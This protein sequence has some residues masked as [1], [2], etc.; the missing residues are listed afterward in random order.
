M[1]QSER[2][3]LKAILKRPRLTLRET[4]LLAALYAAQAVVCV[5]LLKLLFGRFGQ[6]GVLWANISAVLALQPGF[7]QS[8][9]TSVIRILA[10]VV[11]AGVALLVHRIPIAPELQ[12]ITA[13]VLATFVCELLWLDTALRTAC[14]AVIIVLS[15]S[16]RHVLTTAEDRCVATI[17]GCLMA[18]VVQMLTG[19]CRRMMV[20]AP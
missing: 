20:R 10:T 9:V 17:A 2:T 5:V 16:E 15:L 11:G 12:L 7:S 3:A 8:V 4:L 14:V 18:L 13:L 19:L 6:E 1:F